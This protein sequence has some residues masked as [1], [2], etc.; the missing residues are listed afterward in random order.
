MRTGFVQSMSN[1]ELVAF[2]IGGGKFW[3]TLEAFS[4]ESLFIRGERGQKIIIKRKRI[5]ELEVI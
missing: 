2:L 4:A 3:G 5:A 1:I